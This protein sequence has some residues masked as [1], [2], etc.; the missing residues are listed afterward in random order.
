MNILIDMN[1]SPEWV[2]IFRNHGIEAEHWS[3]V[4]RP[5]ASDH[6]ILNWAK[7]NKFV[8]FTHDLDFGV[9]LAATGFES[10]SVIQLRYQN[11]VPDENNSCIIQ[12]IKQYH[13]EL[14]AGVLLTVNE[15]KSRVRILPLR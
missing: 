9:I 7:E 10:P 13:K 14:E 11:I 6:E 12:A 2:R 4:G 15:N 3:S 5:D 1:L 8:V